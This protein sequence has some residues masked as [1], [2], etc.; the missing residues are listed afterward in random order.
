LAVSTY[1]SSQHQPRPP[2]KLTQPAV[3]ALE[4][5]GDTASGGGGTSLTISEC[6]DILTDAHLGDS[7]SIN[8]NPG[9]LFPRPQRHSMKPT[10]DPCDKEPAS[11]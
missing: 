8:G 10:A 7:I 6:A 11:P 9:L 5:Q 3:S 2:A 4:K 1:I